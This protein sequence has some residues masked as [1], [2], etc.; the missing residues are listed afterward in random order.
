MNQMI[1]KYRDVTLY[2]QGDWNKSI[3]KDMIYQSA[4]LVNYFAE[5]LAVRLP[6]HISKEELKSA[7]IIGLMDAIEKIRSDKRH[8]VS[9]VC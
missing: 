9:D 5:K 2:P 7:G 3:K 8:K 1:E 4:P 6:P